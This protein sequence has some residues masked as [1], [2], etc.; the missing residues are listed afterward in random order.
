ME[1]PLSTTKRT[2]LYYDNGR[3]S[4]PACQIPRGNYRQISMLCYQTGHNSDGRRS[5][6]PAKLQS[7][8]QWNRDSDCGIPFQVS[9]GSLG[10][11][12]SVLTALESPYG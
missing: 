3:I 9:K 7:D 12:L 4:K 5:V 11:Y 8:L 6:Q 1:Y 10:R 2:L